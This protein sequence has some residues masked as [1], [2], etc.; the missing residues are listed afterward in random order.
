M[1]TKIRKMIP[2]NRKTVFLLEKLERVTSFEQTFSEGKPK[3]T[4]TERRISKIYI[5]EKSLLGRIIKYLTN[6]ELDR[7]ERKSKGN[8]FKLFKHC[9]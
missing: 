5:N 4:S 3:E 6:K 1:E 8:G 2:S 7:L 9:L